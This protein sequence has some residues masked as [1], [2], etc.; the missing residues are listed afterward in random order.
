MGMPLLR[1]RASRAGA[2]AVDLPV[3]EVPAAAAG[4]M[5]LACAGEVVACECAADFDASSKLGRALLRAAGLGIARPADPS[6]APTLHG[7]RL[8]YPA[9]DADARR[10]L[11]RQLRGL[12]RRLGADATP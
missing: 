6:Q 1:A 8:A 2:P 12:R 10:A 4:A 9:R 7:P 5:T 11:W 3:G